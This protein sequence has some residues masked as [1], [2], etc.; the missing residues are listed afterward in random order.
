MS[1]ARSDIRRSDLKTGTRSVLRYIA[2]E[3]DEKNWI[4]FTRIL[5]LRRDVFENF[6]NKKISNIERNRSFTSVLA[7]SEFVIGRFFGI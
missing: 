1:R 3:L 4:D 2:K 5:F 7:L 6:R